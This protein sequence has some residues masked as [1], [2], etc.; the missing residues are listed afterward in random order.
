MP[1]SVP[2]RYLAQLTELMC[3]LCAEYSSI[4]LRLLECRVT[5]SINHDSHF[6]PSTF[7]W[8]TVPRVSAPHA[9]SNIR[10]FEAVIPHDETEAERKYR[11]QALEL[12]KWHHEF[13]LAHNRVY[14]QVD[15][16]MV[17]REMRCE[18]AV[19]G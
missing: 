3:L 1:L 18:S 10:L 14:E 12:Q 17:G 2:S 15:I 8:Q 13:W 16:R 19:N 9:V 11:L 4:Q 6:P 5:V 7:N